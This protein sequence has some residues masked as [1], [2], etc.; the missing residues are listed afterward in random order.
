MIS[1]VEGV[2]V[3]RA[4]LEDVRSF[5]ALVNM[6]GGAVF[7]RAT[8]GQYNFSM[9][10][11]MSDLALSATTVEGDNMVGY[12]A[13]ADCP[14][15]GKEGDAFDKYILR[16][17]EFMPDFNCM[18][19]MFINFLLL[20]ERETYDMDAVGFDLIYNAFVHCPDTDYFVWMCPSSVKLTPWTLA[21]FDKLDTSGGEESK[22]GEDE[23]KTGHDD[24][25]KGVTVLYCPRSAIFPKLLVRDAR[26]EDNDDLLPVLRDSNPFALEGQDDYFL[27]DLIQSQDE[28]NRFF[29]GV[30]K[31]VPAGMLATSL[32]VNVNLIRKVFNTDPFPDMFIEKE[33]SPP[34]PPLVICL[35][36]DIRAV[37]KTAVATVM[38]ETRCIYLNVE[39]MGLPVV[40]ATKEGDGTLAG[41]DLEAA[42]KVVAQIKAA[43]KSKIDASMAS[44][45][46]A[47]L[48]VLQGF[49]R[50]D[51]EAQL[52]ADREISFDLVLEMRNDSDEAS[53]DE[54]DEILVNHIEAVEALQTFLTPENAP[55][56]Q[57]MG[58]GA[59]ENACIEDFSGIFREL[60][61]VRVREIE[62][63]VAKERAEPPK[64]NAFAVTVFCMKDGY[65]SRGDDILRVVFEDHAQLDY[66]LFMVP[67]NTSKL[68]SV[69][70]L[71]RSMVPLRLREGV[72]FDQTLF[73]MHR[74][75]F[76]A[77]SSPLRVTRLV[78][79]RIDHL[80]RFV[81]P[82]GGSTAEDVVKE[83]NDAMKLND[84]DLKENPASACFEVK[85]LGE[86]VGVVV[87]NRRFIGNDDINWLRSNFEIESLVNFDRHRAKAQSYV[88]QFLINPAF[89]RFTR[90]VLREIMRVMIK[91]LL[92]FQPAQHGATPQELITEM[93]PVL[94]RRRMEPNPGDSLPLR[95]RPSAGP[96]VDKPLFHLTK[97]ML[98]K[99][100]KSV[101]KRVVVVGGSG[102][103]YA[104]LEK[105]CFDYANY[106]NIFLVTDM[107]SACFK[108]RGGASKEKL[109][110]SVE[111]T[112]GANYTNAVGGCLSPRDAD[113]PSLQELQAL[114][115][116]NRVTLV[117]GRVTDIDRQSQAI[118]VDDEKVLEYDVLVLATGV[119]DHS[120]K[121][122]P[123]TQNMHISRCEA[124]GIF[125]LGDAYTDAVALEW[126][127]GLHGDKTKWPVVVSG[128]G[129]D[130]IGVVGMLIKNGVPLR[131]VTLVLESDELPEYPHDIFAEAIIRGLRSSGVTVHRLHDVKDVTINDQNRLE[132]VTIRKLFT[133][134]DMAAARLA[135]K[136]MVEELVEVPAFTL[137]TCTSKS[138][139]PDLF[140]AINESGIVFDGGVVVNKDFRTVDPNIYAVGDFS[141]FSRVHVKEE[142]HLQH[143]S[144]ELGLYVGAVI[145]EQHLHSTIKP[146][147]EFKPK[148]GLPDFVQPRSLSVY[149][150]GGKLFYHAKLS[151]EYHDCNVLL[152]GDLQSDRM[153][154][155][156]L[157]PFGVVV[158]VAY[159][160]KSTVEARNLSKLVGW[161]ESYL[162]EAIHSY[163]EGVVTDWI[164]FFREEWA[165][166][167]YHD[168]FGEFVEATRAV[169]AS[170]KGTYTILDSVVEALEAST[171]NDVVIEEWKK[172]IGPRGQFL[173]ENTKRIV[174]MQT[175]DYLRSNKAMLTRFSI[176]TK[177]SEAKSEK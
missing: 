161:H 1:M 92:F 34:L 22:G 33:A 87:V 163:E 175:V 52:M 169:L 108:P 172:A 25:L 143:N 55:Q 155:L 122:M 102:S 104:L 50:C 32:D 115:L 116:S 47:P 120:Y 42:M 131:R 28:N 125:G 53:E 165:C 76:L 74:D 132:S 39:L 49:P 94:P 135:G 156:K 170:D 114:G 78:K 152:T 177:K 71:T 154:A 139:D 101:L 66:C 48:C 29:V 17:Q 2:E 123:T 146:E 88:T 124:S 126:V 127:N 26:I 168:K 134:E 81:Q 23:S 148:S 96:E 138:C 159:L 75:M 57:R 30:H 73:V 3:R 60:V 31:N 129:L 79:D 149:V 141:V 37:D 113:D 144:R 45:N 68:E 27:A 20:D 14:S 137:L 110:A 130:A 162:N 89:S 171:E 85:L 44:G 4:V 103:S 158:E 136:E 15:I 157:D 99:P 12:L 150:A 112:F 118:V 77:K 105:L 18:N 153:C 24:P 62:E 133:K 106:P 174:E 160:G 58:L 109:V 56:W 100:K 61:G 117:H 13:V 36:G 145:L 59:E 16:L 67:N 176:P 111:S 93:C 164:D 5:N 19:T 128:R 121:K 8:F 173:D 10:T 82:L 35:L 167:I 70:V 54:S 142:P 65:D 63:I 40:P 84:M 38:D 6:S 147:C 151:K 21:T 86:M 51:G 83:C 7:F 43:I 64:P 46:P 95:A 72:T 41:E 11:E 69:N 91:T 98:M 97:L 140:T 107:P 166:A 80:H 9:L 90:F 119:K